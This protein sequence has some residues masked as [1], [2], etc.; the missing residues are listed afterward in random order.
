MDQGWPAD[1]YGQPR[2]SGTVFAVPLRDDCFSLGRIA[3]GAV[4]E[5][6]DLTV[7]SIEDA[8]QATV[9]GASVLFRI[10][11]M[12]RAFSSGRWPAVGRLDLSSAELAFVQP[13][14]HQDAL[15]G[16][17][18]IYS[19]DRIACAV[20]KRPSTYE[21]CLSLERASV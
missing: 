5:F 1:P 6:Y 17:L 12:R 2:P 10:V 13:F 4:C 14:A 3:E 19:E 21:E 7:D 8:K 20:N 11:V 9:E 18:S 16:E 15:S